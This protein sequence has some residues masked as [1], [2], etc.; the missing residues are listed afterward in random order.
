MRNRG[1]WNPW[2]HFKNTFIPKTTLDD[3]FFEVAQFFVG[4]HGQVD[5]SVFIL[6]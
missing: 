5:G 4:N 6:I 2:N 3:Y 1:S